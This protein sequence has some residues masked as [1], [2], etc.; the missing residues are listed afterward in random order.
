[1]GRKSVKGSQIWI[2]GLTLERV[3]H[4]AEGQTRRAGLT[5]R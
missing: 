1:M 5:A 2:V 4:S 3:M